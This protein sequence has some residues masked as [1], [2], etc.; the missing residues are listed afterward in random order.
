MF[1]CGKFCLHSYFIELLHGVLRD[2][3]GS[4]FGIDAV[5]APA[6]FPLYA[7]VEILL[8]LRTLEFAVSHF[9]LT[10]LKYFA[11]SFVTQLD[12]S[13]VHNVV[14]GYFSFLQLGQRPLSCC[15]LFVHH[16]FYPCTLLLAELF[17]SSDYGLFDSLG[18][19][20][21]HFLLAEA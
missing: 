12:Q 18:F 11:L 14:E 15:L 10:L 4:F 6:Y 13:C 2:D 16:G 20:G 21:S 1:F 17:V 7:L 19:D 5:F 8:G 3:V 9:C